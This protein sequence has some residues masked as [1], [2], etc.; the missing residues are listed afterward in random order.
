MS[1]RYEYVRAIYTCTESMHINYGSSRARS[2]RSSLSRTDFIIADCDNLAMVSINH[3]DALPEK[4]IQSCTENIRLLHNPQLAEKFR[5]G[6][7]SCKA[8]PSAEQLS[9]VDNDDNEAVLE[10]IR[11]AIESK[12][13]RIIDLR[14]D[15]EQTKCLI[16]DTSST[17]KG[18]AISSSKTS[19]I[20]YNA[21]LNRVSISSEDEKPE[22]SML[23]LLDN[24]ILW[25]LQR[26]LTAGAEL[27]VL[28]P[29]E[30]I[31]EI[32]IP[33]LNQFEVSLI[34]SYMGFITREDVGVRQFSEYISVYDA[35]NDARFPNN[36]YWF[37]GYGAITGTKALINKGLV[38]DCLA[39]S[40]S[41]K[42]VRGQSDGNSVSSLSKRPF[43]AIGLSNVIFSIKDTI[44]EEAAFSVYYLSPDI[45]YNPETRSVSV[46]GYG[47]LNSSPNLS[48]AI[49]LR[50]SIDALLLN[51]V[52][53]TK[54]NKVGNIIIP[55]LVINN[56]A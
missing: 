42:C 56:V 41:L 25:D 8:A 17:S 49:P 50:I 2:E 35:P 24:R 32:I 33:I 51:P 43:G 4:S 44:H 39:D 23:K 10:S 29:P 15:K 7:G 27:Q 53:G 36:Q 11:M 54:P 30:I 1:K 21:H 48:Y 37:D 52:V 31:R 20:F 14:S 26:T 13:G 3:A 19:C 47:N 18:Q 40:C 45:A 34:E 55:G 46:L 12:G 22:C 38:N 6:I 5:A 16:A 28:L 9:L